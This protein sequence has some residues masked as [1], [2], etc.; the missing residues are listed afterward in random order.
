M[1]NIKRQFLCQGSHLVAVY[2]SKFKQL[3]CNI[4]WGE[5][6]LISQFQFGLQ[7]D[8]KNLLFTLQD[9]STLSQAIEQVVWCDN[10]LFEC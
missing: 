3:A 7:G 8:V 10:K 2:A 1:S 5:V 6:A 9:P 4:S